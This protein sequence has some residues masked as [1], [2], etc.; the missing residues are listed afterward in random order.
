MPW[1]KFRPQRQWGRY[2]TRIFREILNARNARKAKRSFIIPGIQVC[3]PL[4]PN[5]EAMVLGEHKEQQTS[6]KSTTP[7]QSQTDKVIYLHYLKLKKW[8]NF[9]ITLYIRILKRGFLKG[10]LDLRMVLIKHV[11]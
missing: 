4:Q 8:P 6:I 11:H 2:N 10:R 3:D 1:M 7:I 5:F 9:R